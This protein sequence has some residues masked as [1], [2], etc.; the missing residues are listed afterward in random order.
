MTADMGLRKEFI[1]LLSTKLAEELVSREMIEAPEV[2][3]LSEEIYRVIDAEVSIEDRIN[4]EVRGILNQLQDQKRQT[5]ASY[6]EMFK[7]VKNKLVR[8]RKIVL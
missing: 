4:D 3:V 1:R 2:G 8:E 5:G 7:L 6:Q